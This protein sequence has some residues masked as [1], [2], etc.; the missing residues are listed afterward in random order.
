M[1]IHFINYVIHKNKNEKKNQIFKTK[2]T[3]YICLLGHKKTNS[4]HK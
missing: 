3:V 2:D 4:G 1:I